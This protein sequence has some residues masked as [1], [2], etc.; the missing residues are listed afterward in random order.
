MGWILVERNARADLSQVK[1]LT[2]YPELR[3]VDR[4][5]IWFTVAFATLL[6]LVGGSHALV[7]GYFVSTVVLW[8]GTFTIN[9][10]SH[11]WG[12][13]RYQTT[14]DS[15]NNPLLAVLTFGEGWHNNHHRY[16]RAARNGFYWWEFDPTWYV[17]RAMAAVGLVWGIQSVPSRIYEEARVV[18]AAR[19]SKPV[20]SVVDAVPITL[21]LAQDAEPL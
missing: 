1:D 19:A 2:R 8:H 10:L 14:D 13:R 7:W 4:H 6:F 20:A 11:V 18:K 3:F 17:I 12:W 15:R 5:A 16:Q 21:E 9:S